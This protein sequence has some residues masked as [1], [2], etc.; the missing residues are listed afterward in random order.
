MK[1]LY[2]N[3]T[4]KEALDVLIRI[5]QEYAFSIAKLVIATPLPKVHISAGG[6]WP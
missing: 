2:F 5:F 4:L 3:H 6:F 1:P